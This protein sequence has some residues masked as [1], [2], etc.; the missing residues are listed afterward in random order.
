MWKLWLTRVFRWDGVL[1]V[2]ILLVPFVL[3][4][5]FPN[6]RGAIELAS[7]ILPIGGFV[8]RFLVGCHFI[9][10][11]HCHSA[12]QT[13]QTCILVIGLGIMTLLDCIIIL[14]VL[15]PQGAL[16]VN[17]KDIAIWVSLYGTYLL[18]MIIAMYPGRAPIERP[19]SIPKPQ[20]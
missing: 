19:T 16:M 18:L 4:F 17:A 5:L 2:V 13:L 6:Q 12:F 7:I 10:T 3:R 14:S 15:M 11:N 9:N 20:I 8:I 1:P